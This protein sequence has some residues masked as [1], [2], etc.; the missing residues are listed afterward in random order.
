MIFLKILFIIIFVLLSVAFFTIIER[1]VFSSVQRRKGP[2]TVG[3]FGLFQAFSDGF[4]LFIKELVIP[5]SA[6]KFLFLLAPV[7]TFFLSISAWFII[8][9]TSTGPIIDVYLSVGIILIISSL[10]VYGVIIGGWSSNSRYAFLGGLRSSAQI[11]S[12]EISI[13][14]CILFIV[15]VTNSFNLTTIV[16]K[17]ENMWFCFPFFPV[18]FLFI[19]S[20]LAETNRH[21][22]DLPEAEA[23]LVSGY[24]VEYSGIG[25]TLFFLGEYTN[26]IIISSL[27]TIFFLGGWHFPF[28]I[29]NGNSFWFGCKTFFCILFFI[30]ARVAF[31]RYRYDQLI[32]L[33]WK[34]FLP[35][36]IAFIL[37]INAFF[38][39]FNLLMINYTIFFYFNLI[40]FSITFFGMIFNQRS[41]L[42]IIFSIELILLSVNLNFIFFSQIFDNFDGVV[43]A[44]FVLAV[45]A[46]ESVVGLAIIV[47]YYQLNK[48]LNS[49]SFV[50]LQGLKTVNSSGRVFCLHQ[51]R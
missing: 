46:S 33:G 26:I 30:W 38:I 47:N 5:S 43:F 49:S 32:K 9:F 11:I 29:F 13:G 12:Y 2:N 3:F 15:S 27:I 51:K 48:N 21:P 8:P 24:N 37:L 19:I 31:P 20:C 7:F 17:Q 6:N 4:K 45:A 40:F 44:I 23:E 35:F 22:F 42:F 1:K 34:T 50:I 41:V 10:G 25:F 39:I 18:F 36:S 16:L 14:F 28:S